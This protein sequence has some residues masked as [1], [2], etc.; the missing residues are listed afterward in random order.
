ME[1]V[2]YLPVAVMLVLATGFVAV[3]LIVSRLMSP[4]RPT[5][6]KWRPTM[7]MSLAEGTSPAPIK[8]YM[9]PSVRVF[10]VEITPIAGCALQRARMVRDRGMAIFTSS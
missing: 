6:E 4:H 7:R 9:V 3:S 5:P 10:D 2:D 1:L 8:F